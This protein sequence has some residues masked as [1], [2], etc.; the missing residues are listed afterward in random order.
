MADGALVVVG[1]AVEDASL[2]APPPRGNMAAEAMDTVVEA[3]EEGRLIRWKVGHIW[4]EVEI[5]ME[6]RSMER[7]ERREAFRLG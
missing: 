4:V 2:A 1:V 6:M 5:L 7:S 3:R